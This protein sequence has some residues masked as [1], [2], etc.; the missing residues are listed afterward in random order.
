M[1]TQDQKTYFAQLKA[2][3]FTVKTLKTRGPRKGE[4][5]YTTKNT[6]TLKRTK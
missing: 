2:N 6:R 4:T 5:S 1:N 3:G